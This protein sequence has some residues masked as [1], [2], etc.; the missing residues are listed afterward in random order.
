[1]FVGKLQK[2]VTQGRMLNVQSSR[3]LPSSDRLSV[4]AATILI[5][6]TISSFIRLPTREITFQI[7]AI[8]AFSVEINI[9][10]IISILVAGITAAGTSLLI[11]E[12]PKYNEQPTFQHW[13]LPALTALVIGIP[14]SQRNPGE[15][16]WLGVG[17]S[18]GALILV[19]IAE[20]IV[21]DPEDIRYSLATVGLTAVS[22]ALFLLLAITMKTS[23]FRL[24][25]ILPTIS[26][27]IGL[28]SL[29]TLYL[30]SRGT[31]AIIS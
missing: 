30:R 17:L 5:A 12:H 18:G 3:H 19:L 24:F 28:T 26:F 25:I 9:H 8:A 10:T 22:F 20:Y 16:W 11:R 27:A 4:L 1:M 6:Y 7:P 29:R 14:L 13:L 23:D 31:W 15:F 2:T 21:V